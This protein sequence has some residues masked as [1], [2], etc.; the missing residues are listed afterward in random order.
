MSLVIYNNAYATIASGTV[1]PGDTSLSVTGGQG[2]RFPLTAG[3]WCYATLI[4]ASTGALEIVKVTAR[5]VD[6]LTI[7][8]SI[9][10]T[11]P[12]TF[13]AG[14][15]IECRPCA[16]ALYEF[17]QV[18]GGTMIGDLAIAAK[19]SLTG[20]ISPAQIT[21]DQN[22]YTPAGLSAAVVMRINSDAQRTITGLTGGQDGRWLQIV[23]VGA[24]R[25]ILS[26]ENA[27]SAA[28]NRFT[29]PNG[30]VFLDPNTTLS[31]VYDSTSSRWRPESVQGIQSLAVATTGLQKRQCVLT[32]KVDTAGVPAFFAD[33]SGGGVAKLNLVATATPLVLA[34]AGGFNASGSIDYISRLTA[35]AAAALNPLANSNTNHVHATYVSNS[36]VTWGSC[37]CPEQDGDQF[38][39]T[40]Q[41]LI[42][43]EDA[44][45]GPVDDFGNSWNLGGAAAINATKPAY[46][47]RSLNLSGGGTGAANV[48]R[49]ESTDFAALPV[50]SWEMSCVTFLDALPATAR[51]DLM[52]AVNNTGFGAFVSIDHNGVN[53]RAML[54]AS[55]TGSSYDIANA[56]RGATNLA[57]NTWY[58]FRMV[59]D[60]L[61]GT[62]RVY[63]AAG[64]VGATP[65]W[66][67][68]VQEITVSSSL[69]I[70]PITRMLI[71]CNY[72]AGYT[73]GISGYV[74]EFRLLPCATVTTTETP[75]GYPLAINAHPIH[76]YSP[77]E[78][79][80]Y[81]VTAASG[82]AGS[83]PTM[84]ARVRLFTAEADTGA[85]TVTAIRC[86]AFLGRFL[87]AIN[88]SWSAGTLIAFADN[89]GT[90]R[91]RV[92]VFAL[93]KANVSSGDGLLVGV[94]VRIT[95][96]EVS[97]GSPRNGSILLKTDRNAS[98]LITGPSG[99]SVPSVGGSVNNLTNTQISL[100]AL[101]ERDY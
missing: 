57:V 82:V 41:S 98:K 46:G 29:L 50:D 99:L 88:A 24:F 97:G 3:Q 1:N 16:A 83:N 94:R 87:S 38:D 19:L 74:D 86:R 22:D 8:R 51:H 33:G 71:G 2:A 48:K 96:T 95:A 44:A 65:V 9:D 55:S 42:H 67:P 37:L 17:L 54:Y 14:D 25:I 66:T 91:G 84:T 68:E 70:C 79:L 20:K 62:Y 58:K 85:G 31:L 43:F 56:Q 81:E 61:A 64:G 40:W 12:Y 36:S 39:R 18:N 53:A 23:N 28:N 30:D 32:G 72:N 6:V 35:D 21:A 4:K 26:N 5:A 63:V 89:L 10:G 60:A 13:N 77:T 75:A 90:R 45:G 47:V 80:M 92:D 7:V 100:Q 101:V 76:W 93:V 73:N 52:C 11:G 78:G 27:A 59:F 49:A 69:R 15:R 34:L